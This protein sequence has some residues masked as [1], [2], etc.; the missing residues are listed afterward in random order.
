MVKTL[1]KSLREYRKTTMLTVLLSVLEVVCEIIIPLLMS[2]LIDYGI[3]GGSM[4]AVWKYSLFIMLFAVAE[5]AAG[6]LSARTASVASA[7]FCGNLRSDMY[8]KVQGFA[9]S[10]IDRFSNSSIVTRLTTDVTNIQNAY[11]M[12]I[13]IAVRGPVMLVISMIVSFQISRDISMIFLLVI[14]ILAVGLV[15]IIHAVGPV[16][17]KV[18]A[19]YDRLNNVVQENVNGIRVVKSFGREAYETEKFR[20][21]SREISSGYTRGEKLIAL[22][23]PLMQ[24]CMYACMIAI[25]WLGAKAVVASGNNAALGLSTGELT[26]LLSYAQQI[27]IAL[28][29]LSMVFA[30]ISI[31]RSSGDRVAELLNAQPDITSPTN[32]ATGIRYG[33]VEFDRVTFS[34]A[35]AAENGNGGA[36]AG[37]AYGHDKPVLD[38]VSLRISPGE[39]IGILGSTGSSK[40]SLVQLI[41]RLY[42]ASSGSVRV[43]G[44]DVK[45]YDLETLR[46]SVAMVLQKNEL[47]TGTIADNLRWGNEKACDEE[48]RQ[49]CRIACADEFIDALPDGYDTKIE[50]GG[51]NVSGGQKQRLCIARALLKKSKILILDDSTS[52]VDTKTDAKIRKGLQ[53]T[54]PGTTKIMIAQRISSLRDA[55][56]ILV[57]DEGRIADSGTHEELLS[58]C[59]IYQEV[60]HSQ[61]R[62]SEA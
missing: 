5:L 51:A 53:E 35:K 21:I 57:M 8:D 50:Q 38:D 31:S 23:S 32:A 45:S 58:R 61:V 14:P 40:S 55:D 37:Q 29:S 43:G 52:A 49:A 6:V 24:L 26:A 59:A 22:N 44:I 11:M 30:M 18:F 16:F 62:G 60:Y 15:L 10:N 19:T 36:E 17:K 25:S 1:L 4:P 41:P 2:D 27:M 39:T 3:T 28:M 56:R 33:S 12:L 42:D 9:F 13:R 20:S 7:G 47:F 34:Y 46:N 54:L 48:L